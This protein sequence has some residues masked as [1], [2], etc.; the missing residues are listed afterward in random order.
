MIKWMNKTD[1]KPLEDW[2]RDLLAENIE[3]YYSAMKKFGMFHHAE[4]DVGRDI[5]CYLTRAM[6][7]YDPDKSKL[8]TFI[9]MYV[10]FGLRTARRKY[11]DMLKEKTHAI[12]SYKT[13]DDDDE[14]Q[15]ADP[16]S[17]D[18]MEKQPYL[19]EELE[20]SI[21]FLP[22]QQRQALM[23]YY[24]DGH[25]CDTGGKLMGLSKQRYQ[26]LLT[27]ALNK[28]KLLMPKPNWQWD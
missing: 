15:I 9:Y 10:E 26:Q 25:T 8:S 21:K 24:R 16:S 23:L 11:K 18:A 13:F 1:E 4:T 5:L 22:P 12:S 7:N 28:L 17:V 3:L 2:Q 14:M 27:N 19:I 20:E 6:R